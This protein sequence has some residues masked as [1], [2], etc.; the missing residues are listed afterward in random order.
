MDVQTER[1]LAI[2]EATPGQ[3]DRSL[4]FP[5]PESRDHHP[6]KPVRSAKRY[7]RIDTFEQEFEIVNV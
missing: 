3:F 1:K 4:Q 2:Y 5:R 6:Q 7:T